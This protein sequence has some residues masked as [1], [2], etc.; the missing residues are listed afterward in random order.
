MPEELFA[1]V[2]HPI[3]RIGELT[4]EAVSRRAYSFSESGDS[5]KIRMSFGVC[6]GD[7]VVEVT[8]KGVPVEW[9]Y[10]QLVELAG[11]SK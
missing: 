10:E 3:F 4:Q 8:A 6:Y 7:V 1:I 11:E 2:D 9:V 5:G